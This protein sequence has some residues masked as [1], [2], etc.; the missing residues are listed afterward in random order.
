MINIAIYDNYTHLNTSN[1]CHRLHMRVSRKFFEHEHA[2]MFG[3]IKTK[4]NRF[5]EMLIYLIRKCNNKVKCCNIFR[6]DETQSVAV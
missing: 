6:Y 5:I 4:K 2:I 1:I 3:D